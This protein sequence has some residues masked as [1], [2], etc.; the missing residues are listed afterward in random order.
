MKSKPAPKEPPATTRLPLP[1]A[2]KPMVV[3]RHAVI[4]PPSCRT[5]AVPDPP[6]LSLPVV[7]QLPL[8]TV[9]AAVDPA[10]SAS[11]EPAP[12]S[13]KTTPPSMDISA[14]PQIPMPRLVKFAQVPPVI[15][16]VPRPP[17]SRPRKPVPS[18][19]RPPDRRRVPVPASPITISPRPITAP[20]WSVPL[21]IETVPSPPAS[22]PTYPSVVATFPPS[23]VRSPRPEPPIVN[24][25]EHSHHPPV[26]PT[27]P[28]A[29]AAAPT[30]P[31]ALSTRPLAIVSDPVPELPT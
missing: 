20:D 21:V 11:H 18:S 8:V 29:S 16:A 5:V 4:V 19:I 22:R 25:S 10:C 9:T 23:I 15:T 1:V 12:S 24:G 17:A 14:A 26:S 28:L 30:T 7:I 13:Q 6:M 3:D 2:S 31:A 27:L